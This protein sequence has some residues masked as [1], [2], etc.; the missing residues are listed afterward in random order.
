MSS[1]F[2]H[3]SV[4]LSVMSFPKLPFSGNRH[5]YTHKH[6]KSD[7]KEN[8]KSTQCSSK[9]S[10]SSCSTYVSALDQRKYTVYFEAFNTRL[11]EK[12]EEEA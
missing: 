1:G 4:L 7:E 10:L 6:W 2:N 9:L 8:D 12:S 11:Q 3:S 5:L